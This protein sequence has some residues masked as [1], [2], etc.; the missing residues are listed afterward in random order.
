MS[1]KVFFFY[2]MC[3]SKLWQTVRPQDACKTPPG[4]S[5]TQ[6]KEEKI[7][8]RNSVKDDKLQEE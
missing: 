4:H 7:T 8:F 1:Q 2:P 6:N 5:E 3:Q